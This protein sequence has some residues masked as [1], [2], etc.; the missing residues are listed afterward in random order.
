MDYVRHPKYSKLLNQFIENFRPFIYRPRDP[1]EYP[2]LKDVEITGCR[3]RRGLNWRPG[4][5][6]NM[7]NYDDG[8]YNFCSETYTCV[9]RLSRNY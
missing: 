9:A 7:A 4:N 8:I 1:R 3:R 6:L 5:I 2:S